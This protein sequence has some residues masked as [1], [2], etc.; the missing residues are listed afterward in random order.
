MPQRTF[1]VF[2]LQTSGGKSLRAALFFIVD[3]GYDIVVIAMVFFLDR[4]SSSQS[5]PLA[6]IKLCLFVSTILE[7]SRQNKL[8]YEHPFT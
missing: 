6:L 7:I 3:E 1:L 4:K 8:G 5:I 2:L